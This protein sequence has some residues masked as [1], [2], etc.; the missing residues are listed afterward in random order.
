MTTSYFYSYIETT[1]YRTTYTVTV[2]LKQSRYSLT[3]E[4]WESND[5]YNWYKVTSTTGRNNKQSCGYSSTQCQSG[6]CEMYCYAGCETTCNVQTFSCDQHS[7]TGPQS[8]TASQLASSLTANGRWIVGFN[9]PIILY[10][11]ANESVIVSAG[12][13]SYT[14]VG[15]Y[16]QCY[17]AEDVSCQPNVHKAG[18]WY[19]VYTYTC[20]KRY[21]EWGRTY[22]L[23]AI[24][25]VDWDTGEVYASVNQTSITFNIVR[26]TIAR[27]KYVLKESWSRTWEVILEPPPPEPERCQQILNDP[28]SRCDKAWCACLRQFDPEA[29]RNTDCCQ[30]ESC[31]KVSIDIC[32]LE[33][34]SKDCATLSG[35]G[36]RVCER[37]P[38][39]GTATIS[40][41]W[42]ISWSVKE[43]WKLDDIRRVG[44]GKCKPDS[45]TDRSASKTCTVTAEPR[46]NYYAT[47]IVVFKQA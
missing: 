30:Q 39:G 18:D 10:F 44:D 26:N 15:D 16:S 36:G 8:P 14:L 12:W 9:P 47:L 24:E 2:P 43:G 29:W 23:Q 42:S 35:G 28:N 17:T 21:V 45:L 37:I 34:S 5:G 11:K 32:C 46:R 38:E 7:C 1:S 40:V 3:G 4:W 19:C 25:L 27:F 22:K 6:A 33:T 13:T 20:I 41:S 31:Y